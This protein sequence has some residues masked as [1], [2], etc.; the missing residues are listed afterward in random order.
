MPIFGLMGSE[1]EAENGCESVPGPLFWAQVNTSCRQSLENG[2]F[3]QCG[4]IFD[5]A[6]DDSSPHKVTHS[7]EQQIEE[8]RRLFHVGITRAMQLLCVSCAERG[9]SITKN[10]INALPVLSVSFLT[11]MLSPCVCLIQAS[12]KTPQRVLSVMLLS[13]KSHRPLGGCV[14]VHV[15]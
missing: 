8:E 2:R 12:H 6:G 7:D 14:A 3:N 15:L 4:R 13:A 5:G 1:H 9:V 11:S 10:C